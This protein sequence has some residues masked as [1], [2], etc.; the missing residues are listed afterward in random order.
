VGELRFLEYFLEHAEVIEALDSGS[1][2][3]VVGELRPHRSDVLRNVHYLQLRR[4]VQRPV[5]VRGLLQAVFH[6][7]FYS[8]IIKNLTASANQHTV[9]QHYS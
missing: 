5:F 6:N 9:S 1:L 3:L 7:K 4:V 8:L 2:D